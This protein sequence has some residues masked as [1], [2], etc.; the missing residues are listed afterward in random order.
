M[1]SSEGGSSADSSAGKSANGSAGSGSSGLTAV[2]KARSIASDW[3]QRHKLKLGLDDLERIISEDAEMDCTTLL[4]ILQQTESMVRHTLYSPC[5]IHCTHHTLYSPY[6]VLTIHCTHHTPY[7]IHHTPYTMH[8]TPYTIH[9]TLTGRFRRGRDGGG[10][11]G[12]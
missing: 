5:I 8:H 9:H 6:T 1:Q 7:T 11:G 3:A 4:D 2:V 10:A 12:Y